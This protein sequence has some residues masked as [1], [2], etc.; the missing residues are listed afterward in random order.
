MGADTGRL[1]A[2]EILR[3]LLVGFL[4]AGFISLISI[5]GYYGTLFMLGALK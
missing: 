2:P 1:N 3:A 5:A 4:F